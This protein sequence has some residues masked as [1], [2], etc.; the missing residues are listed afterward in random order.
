MAQFVDAACALAA[1]I[2]QSPADFPAHAINY[3]IG[4]LDESFAYVKAEQAAMRGTDGAA[5]RYARYEQMTKWAEELS[6]HGLKNAIR[7][8][9]DQSARAA[10]KETIQVIANDI[11]VSKAKIRAA[12]P[13]VITTK[14]GDLAARWTVTKMRIGI[15]NVAG[16]KIT[17]GQGLTASTHKLGGGGS[18]HLRVKRAF[19]MSANGGE[20]VVYRIGRSRYPVKAVYAETPATALG[21]NGA[22]AQ[23]MWKDTAN[24]ELNAR[25][26]VEIQKQ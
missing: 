4:L 1:T 9:V 3:A 8:A 17:I 2:L 25:L 11:G 14:A 19:V 26:A 7:R 18:S 13:K 22:P 5:R 16:A 12:T 24:R 20:A 6:A 10:R 21:Q 15:R 23:K